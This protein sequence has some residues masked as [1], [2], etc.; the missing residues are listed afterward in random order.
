MISGGRT[1]LI[2]TLNISSVTPSDAGVY[3]CGASIYDNYST[4]RNT[5]QLC[6][7]G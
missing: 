6:A 5:A 3:E 1:S 4:V 2:T 7:K